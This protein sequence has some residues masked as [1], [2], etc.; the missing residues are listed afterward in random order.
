MIRFTPGGWVP[1]LARMMSG[2]EV[3]VP[4][5]LDMWLTNGSEVVSFTPRPLFTLQEDSW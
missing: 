2:K 5:F 4:H 3:K 1:E